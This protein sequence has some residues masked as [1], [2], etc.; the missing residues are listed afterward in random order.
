[1]SE[2]ESNTLDHNPFVF[3]SYHTESTLSFVEELSDELY[4]INIK[5]WYAKRD[6]NPLKSYSDVIP[7]IISSCSLV[8]ILLNRFSNESDQVKNE[9]RNAYDKKKPILIIKIDDCKESDSFDFL[10]SSIQF[11]TLNDLNQTMMIKKICYELNIF[12][13]SNVNYQDNNINTERKSNVLDFYT[14]ENERERI[15]HQRFFLTEFAKKDFNSILENYKNFSILDIGCNTGEQCINMIER[16]DNLKLYVGIDREENAINYAKNLWNN[17]KVFFYG[18][19]CEKKDFENKLQDIESNHNIKGFDIIFISMVLLHIKQPRILLDKVRNHINPNGKIVIIDIDDGF[20]IAYPD[21]KQHFKKA[22]DI[23]EYTSFSGF[24]KSGR[25]IYSYL[26]EMDMTNIKLH[27]CG[28][29]TINMDRKQ[30]DDFFNIYFWFILDDLRIMHNNNPD[31]KIIESDY[32]WINS[33]YDDMRLT[34]KK[35]D[36]FFTLGFMMFSAE[37]DG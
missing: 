19:D 27:K 28:L 34:F 11:L 18:L 33:V 32:K 6:I 30:R 7:K 10:K 21:T 25:E 31:S 2:K 8:V 24:R 16:T 13:S 1:M 14:Y 23:C 35:K 15:Q 37:Q 17:P 4:R 5:H 36:F 26:N 9:F 20:N 22:I 12:F 3:I 29:S